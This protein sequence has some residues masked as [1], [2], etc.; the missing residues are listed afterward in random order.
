MTANRKQIL[1]KISQIWLGVEREDILKILDRYGVEVDE[2]SR[3]RVQLAVLKLSDGDID[4][5]ADL[6]Q[7]AKKDYRDV[8]AWAEYPEE[9]RT[10]PAE[11]KA[12]PPKEVRAIRRRDREQYLQWLYGGDNY[13]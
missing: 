9:M 11:M 12:L 1:I 13:G 10:S 6:V 4:K 5:L 8:L 7:I 3:S 2:D